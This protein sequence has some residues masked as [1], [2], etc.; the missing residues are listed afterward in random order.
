M[1]FWQKTYL[2]IMVI[3]IISFNLGAYALFSKSYELNKAMDISAG[4]N[5]FESIEKALSYNLET[6]NR[7]V[8]NPD[9]E[10]FISNFAINYYKNDVFFEIFEKNHL[11]FSNAYKINEKRDETSFDGVKTIYRKINGDLVLFVSGT[12]DFNNLGLV[13]SRSADYLGDFNDNLLSYFITLNIIISCLLSLFLII[14]L[15]QLTKP[16]RKLNAAVNEIAQNSYGR[17]VYIKRKDEIGELANNFNKMADAISENIANIEKANE[18]KETFINNLTHEL[19]TPITAIK[20]YGDFLKNARHDQSEQELAINYIYEHANRLNL[21][22]DKLVQLL[23][24]KKDDIE[25][26]KINTEKLFHYIERM[27]SHRLVDKNIVLRKECIAEEVFA[28][29]VLLQTLLINLV[30]NSIKSIDDVGEIILR[31]IFAD[32]GTVLKVIDTGRGIEK[33]HIE[34]ITEAFYVVDKSRSKKFGGVGLGLSICK[35][36]ARLHNTRLTIVS[37]PNRFTEVSIF[38]TSN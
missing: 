3:F 20:G 30:E 11:I 23:Y 28:D 27:V 17:R 36:I 32:G 31:S 8:E 21:L 12:I 24:L 26:I 38:F 16:I 9:I 33:E 4:I 7:D 22:S 35:E 37:L 5:E 14:I 2:W 10:L 13:M 15:L 19:K 6:Y 25:P 18:E 34:R 29:E 1:K